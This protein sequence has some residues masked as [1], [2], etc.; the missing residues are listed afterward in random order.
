MRSAAQHFDR[1]PHLLGTSRSIS[2]DPN[3]PSLDLARGSQW[4]EQEFSARPRPYP[5]P[6]MSAS[7]PLPSD[8]AK[9]ASGRDQALR[10]YRPGSSQDVHPRSPAQFYPSGSQG[11]QQNPLPTPRMYPQE[12]PA[13]MTYVYRKPDEAL[14]PPIPM[15]FPPPRAQGI[16]D[17]PPQHSYDPMTGRGAPPPG[18]PVLGRPPPLED[19]GYTSPKSQRKTKGHVASACVPCKKAHLR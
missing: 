3:R 10:N 12:P 17:G 13:T 1:N 18:Y 9:E 7:S 16:R 11:Q 4:A 6:P 14:P 2:S 15:S 19:H 8:K 5:S